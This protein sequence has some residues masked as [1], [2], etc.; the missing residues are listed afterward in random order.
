MKDALGNDLKPGDL[1]MLSLDR[2]QV[3]G[4]VT[5]VQEGGLITGMQKNGGAQLRPSRVTILAN[6]TIEGDPRVPV[7]SV[8]ILRDPDA[9]K[10]R[11]QP[12]APVLETPN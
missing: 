1:V 7:G 4:R 6:H 9:E 10:Q 11:D 3:F 8:V 5:D 2:P 12:P